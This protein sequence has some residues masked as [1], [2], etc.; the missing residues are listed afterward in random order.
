MRVVLRLLNGLDRI[1]GFQFCAVKVRLVYS[2]AL[3]CLVEHRSSCR[4]NKAVC[5]Y[6]CFFIY[7]KP[8]NLGSRH[9]KGSQ[10]AVQCCHGRVAFETLQV[11]CVLHVVIPANVHSRAHMFVRASWILTFSTM[12][13][14]SLLALCCRALFQMSRRAF[15]VVLNVRIRL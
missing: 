9:K 6:L 2:R 1:K 13:A 12:Q 11:R 4:N 15:G 10:Q 14:D 5:I 7:K 8:N 3:R